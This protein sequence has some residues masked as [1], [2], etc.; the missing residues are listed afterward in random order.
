MTHTP[1]TPFRIGMIVVLF[2]LVKEWSLTLIAR[3]EMIA[4]WW[5]P[6]GVLLASLLMLPPRQWRW[7]ILGIIPMDLAVD[8][9]HGRPLIQSGLFLLANL[10]EAAVGAWLVLRFLRP[11]EIFTD[12][13]GYFGFILLSGVVTPL[14][15]A[16]IGAYAATR[17]GTAPSF[18]SVYTVWAISAGLGILFVAPAV[19]LWSDRTTGI[20]QLASREQVSE[21]LL[22]LVVLV[23][24]TLAVFFSPRFEGQN[25][26]LFPYL[27]FPLLAW[28]ALR[29]EMHGVTIA[30][31]F[32]ASLAIWATVNSHGPFA[33]PQW[34]TSRS[35]FLLQ[36]FLCISIVTSMCIAILTR[37]A[38]SRMQESMERQEE[39]AL[40]LSRLQTLTRLSPV[41]I[42]HTDALGKCTYVNETWSRIAGISQADAKESGWIH[43]LH[44]EDRVR[45]RQAWQSATDNRQSFRDEYRFLR[46]DGA[47]AWVLGQASAQVDGRGRV[48][49]YVGTITDITK[50]KRAELE[51]EAEQAFTQATIDALSDTFFLFDPETG[52]ALR[53]NR[54]FRT[55]SGYSDEEIAILKAPHSYYSAND[56]ARAAKTI[57]TVTEEGQAT[58]RI[59]LICKQGRRIPFEYSVTQVQTG[60]GTLLISIGRDI[61]ERRVM[62]ES[63]QQNRARWRGLAQNSPDYIMTLNRQLEILFINRTVPGLSR[64]QVIGMELPALAPNQRH[65]VTITLQRA[66]ETQEQTSYETFHVDPDGR[67]RYFRT[68]VLPI[69]REELEGELLVTS[70][71]ITDQK[72]TEMRLSESQRNYEVI[73]ESSPAMIWYIDRQ[74]RVQRLNRA[75]ADLSGREQAAVIG[76]TALE[77]FPES[78]ARN[79]QQDN[80]EIMA[81]GQARSGIVEQGLDPATGEVRWYRTDKIP[82]VDEEGQVN[83]ITIFASDITREKGALEALETAKE[84]AEAATIAKSE[85]LS[86]MSHEI[87]TP[88]NVVIGMSDILMESVSDPE[89]LRQLRRLQEAGNNLLELINNIL[90][91]SR[92][93]A[94][95]MTVT[96]EPFD[97]AQLLRATVSLFEQ[98]AQEKG[99]ALR[100]HLDSRLPDAVMGDAGSLRRVL[101]NLLSNALK[102][103]DEGSVEVELSWQNS[104][105][106]QAHILVRDSGIGLDPEHIETIFDRFYQVESGM[107]RRFGG[108]G[109]GLAITRQLVEL[110]RGEIRI[111]SRARKGSVF[112][113]EL[114][115]PP[116]EITLSSPTRPPRESFLHEPQPLRILL[117]EDS[118]DNCLLIRAFLKKTPHHL[119]VA[120]D[121]REGV[122]QFR[123][124]GYDMVL[125]DMQMPVMDGYSASRTIRTDSRFDTLPIV[126][127]TANAMAGDREKCLDAGMQDHLAK[128]IDPPEL[129]AAL[130]RWITPRQGL[131]L[132]PEQMLQTAEQKAS[133]LT[134]KEPLPLPEL[135]ELDTT[136]GVARMGGNR[137][138]YLDLLRRFITDQDSTAESIQEALSRDDTETAERLAHTTKGVAGSLGAHAL[139][140]QAQQ[141]EHAMHD[142][143]RSTI[144][145]ALPP[146]KASLTTLIAEISDFVT[147]LDAHAPAESITPDHGSRADALPLLQQL[148]DLVADD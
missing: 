60:E 109:L 3:P 102:F 21:F 121:G 114:P 58:V 92:F 4:V 22:L 128:P 94:G 117:V 42:F 83:G 70:T 48:V 30:A 63:L 52:R 11:R 24:V 20:K 51:R 12:L 25:H 139:Q 108:S 44:P 34:G 45:V 135:D 74:H 43:A 111:E 136:T 131:G 134:E 89:Q 55:I 86:T 106:Y 2:A 7:V 73:L 49:G 104:D 66:L 132:T 138:L 36:A 5:P 28:A 140:Q 123:R 98:V 61:T 38:R 59:S 33:N 96:R 147:T 26:T 107:T 88:M 77:L 16:S 14:L 143:D 127:M 57:E 97:P 112:H 76:K 9:Y 8:L 144:E 105:P 65:T 1:A 137:K 64:E 71:D 125:M 103:T 87:R 124:G 46:S 40:L 75:A 6:N 122:E 53:W 69:S 85:F 67:R 118:E 15:T 37:L 133:P 13:R 119:D 32:L 101:M 68:R 17:F 145:T 115:L 110:M 120:M 95:R 148:H 10:L 47:S 82:N 116:A 146:F 72:R 41:G 99:V 50:R 54:S 130:S 113:V 18:V 100:C 35:V 78:F 93:E 91:L 79:Y 84:Q 29:F 62:E 141:L 39:L 142:Q 81:S 80:E 126:A 27:T 19:V 23:V 129:Y 90:D 56:L 31:L